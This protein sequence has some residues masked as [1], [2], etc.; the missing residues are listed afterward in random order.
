[1]RQAGFF[2]QNVGDEQNWCHVIVEHL[3]SVLERTPIRG[4]HAVELK[5]LWNR[6]GN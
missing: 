2:M 3:D 1:M 6:Q 4:G 5:P